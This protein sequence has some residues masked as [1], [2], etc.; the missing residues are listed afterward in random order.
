[1][2]NKKYALLLYG[3][4]RSYK[5]SAHHIKKNLLDIND[6]DIFISTHREE[7]LS[8]GGSQSIL[9]FENVYGDSFKELSYIEDTDYADLICT[10][11]EKIKNIDKRLYD[12]YKDEIDNINNLK[13]WNIW[14]KKIYGRSNKGFYQRN[15]DEYQYVLHELIMLYHRLNAFRL[16]E[17]YCSKN[18]IKYDGVLVYRP[19]LY[20]SVKLDLSK[21]EINDDTIYFR[22][23]F[24]F[25]SSYEGIKKLV[26]TLFFNYYNQENTK[27]HI[28]EML[29]STSSEHISELEKKIKFWKCL[30]EWQHE[31][32][33]CDTN[34]YKKNFNVLN[35]LLHY[36]ACTDHDDMKLF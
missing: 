34:N 23:E 16:M 24:F 4:L 15:N 8:S 21:F 17:K 13:S 31:I 6:I 18:D 36:R 11:K 2:K 7:S 25:I 12:Q 20:F 26:Y 19:D 27:N 3:N 32:F 14:Y 29:N 33:L 5:K 28:D 22:S 9:K 10:L 30:S 35:T 1:M